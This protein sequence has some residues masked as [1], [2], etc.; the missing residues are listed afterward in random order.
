MQAT[1]YGHSLWGLLLLEHA[2]R[3]TAT[4]K[5]P[6]SARKRPT[7]AHR[8]VQRC[9]MPQAC[10]S[11]RAPHKRQHGCPAGLIAI[12]PLPRVFLSLCARLSGCKGG[13]NLSA[14]P[15]CMART[16]HAWHGMD[17]GRPRST[18]FHNARGLRKVLHGLTPPP[19]TQLQQEGRGTAQWP[20]GSGERGRT[21]V[22]VCCP[23]TCTRVPKP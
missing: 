7:C 2:R 10:V 9:T 13:K 14:Q 5:G 11:K 18:N 16:L 19:G 3:L 15:R 20:R 12:M 22:P 6:W 8:T 1:T 17:C 4:P 21:R 23:P